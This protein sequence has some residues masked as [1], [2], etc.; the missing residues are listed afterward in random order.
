MPTPAQIKLDAD[1]SVLIERGFDAPRHVIWQ[2]FTDGAILSRWLLGPPGWEMEDCQITLQPGGGYRWRWRHA[3]TGQV[4]GFNGTYS[5][6]ETGARLIDKQTFDQGDH[7]LASREITKNTVLFTDEGAG[8]RVSTTV[9]YPD[10]TT[11]DMV[12]AQGL[13]DGMEASYKRLDQML[14]RAAA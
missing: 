11:R 4:F 8:A 9:R 6:V 12:V 14:L 13:C 3:Q 7:A 5:V 2:A 10:A 1:R